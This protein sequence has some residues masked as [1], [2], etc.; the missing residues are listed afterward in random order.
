MRD[1][2]ALSQS[3]T[4]KAK[5]LLGMAADL[6]VKRWPGVALGRTQVRLRVCHLAFAAGTGVLVAGPSPQTRIVA[7]SFLAPSKWTPL[8][9][10]VT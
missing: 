5:E 1:L 6:R 4:G 3:L 10:W 2:P 7:C 8:A 9:K